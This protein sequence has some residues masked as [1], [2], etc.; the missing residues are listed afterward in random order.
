M[1][2]KYKWPDDYDKLKATID[3]YLT[4]ASKPV[5]NKRG[6]RLYLGVCKDTMSEWCTNEKSYGNSTYGTENDRSYRRLI[7]DAYDAMCDE[8]LQ[9]GSKTKNTTMFAMELNKSFG[10]NRPDESQQV[11]IQIELPDGAKQYAE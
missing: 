3:A 7:E 4:D 1:S 9:A 10:Y 11:K 8:L 5:K 6:L 2:A